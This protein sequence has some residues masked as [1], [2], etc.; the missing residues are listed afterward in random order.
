MRQ[1][2]KK[3]DERTIDE[4][5]EAGCFFYVFGERVNMVC[6]RKIKRPVTKP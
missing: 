3:G 5:S 1:P 4:M 2:N 6:V